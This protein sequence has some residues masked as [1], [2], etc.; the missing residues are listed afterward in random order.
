MA[1]SPYF[2]FHR[3]LP[4]TVFLATAFYLVEIHRLEFGGDGAVA[5]ATLLNRVIEEAIR[6]A[7]EQYLWVHRRFKTRPDPKW[8]RFYEKRG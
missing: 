2:L 6:K 8:E 1:N 5:N 4:L 7:P 3:R